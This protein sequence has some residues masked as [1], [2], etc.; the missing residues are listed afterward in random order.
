MLAF[1]VIVNLQDDSRGKTC[2]WTAQS[3]LVVKSGRNPFADGGRP[4]VVVKFVKQVRFV[5][6]QTPAQVLLP[7]LLDSKF[8]QYIHYFRWKSIGV[9]SLSTCFG[10]EF[11]IFM[12]IFSIFKFTFRYTIFTQTV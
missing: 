6:D 8:W 1:I 3:V 2:R 5:C 12:K 9:M 11:R 7:V 4:G 10:E